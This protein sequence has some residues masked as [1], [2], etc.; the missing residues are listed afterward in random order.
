[1]S[2][3]N[4]TPE[5]Q[6]IEPGG[7]EQDGPK[8]LL[9][10]R[11][12]MLAGVA[13]GIGN[14]FNIDANIVRIAFALSIMFGGLGVVAYVALALFVP[15]E[16]DQPGEIKPPV[17]QR[18]RALGIA[19]GVAAALFVLSWG[20][21]DFDPWPF[22]RGGWFFGGPLL[23]LLLAVGAYLVVRG[24][25]RGRD[26]GWLGAVLFGLA[27]FIG[28]GIAF[29]VAF[30]AGATG[31]GVIVASLLIGIGVMLVIAAFNGGAR[32]LI[33]PA[34]VL[35]V[36]LAFVA[37]TDVSF[38][39]GVGERQYRPATIDAIPDDRTYELGIGHLVV[40]LRNI[41]WQSGDVVA[42]DVDL[43]MGQAAV[44]VPEDL[45]VVTNISASMGAINAAGDH[46][47]GF[48]TSHQINHG[49]DATPRLELDGEVQI[50]E[51]RLINDDDADIDDP[52]PWDDDDLTESD[53]RA[54]LEEACV[55]DP[56]DGEAEEDGA[57]TQRERAG[58]ARRD[59][60]RR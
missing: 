58:N 54:A 43:G 38:G 31:H 51:F 22:D 29:A 48:D 30:W 21:A 2:D 12:R 41:D 42:L 5:T 14:Y 34:L 16:G 11:D 59:R 37:A 9:R 44:A 10:S 60:E 15:E 8:R 49:A 7:S 20:L 45:C 56:A 1:M 6:P 53:A 18:S 50:G 36:P 40:D 13:G 17:I 23:F 27:V 57:D 32:W 19:A 4:P 55:A 24:T 46:A 52:H 25:G 39:D 3:Q 35:A 26:L 28:L 47:A 33:A